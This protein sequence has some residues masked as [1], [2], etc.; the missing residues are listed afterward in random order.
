MPSEQGKEYDQLLKVAESVMRSQFGEPDLP[1]G[2][3]SKKNATRW[4]MTQF[5]RK[6]ISLFASFYFSSPAE[7]ES[8]STSET[9]KHKEI[10]RFYGD[11]F[12]NYSYISLFLGPEVFIEATLGKLLQD[13]E[14]GWGEM[15]D[16][17]FTS[18]LRPLGAAGEYFHHFLGREVG[19]IFLDIL[20]ETPKEEATEAWF[21]ALPEDSRIQAWV[22]AQCALLESVA[23]HHPGERPSAVL[24]PTA[25]DWIQLW[26][27]GIAERQ[28]RALARAQCWLAGAECGSFKER[29][30][31]LLDFDAGFG[32]ETFRGFTGFT[33]SRLDL[34]GTAELTGLPERLTIQGDLNLEGCTGLVCLPKALVV[35]GSLILKDCLGF[36]S[37]SADLKVGKGSRKEVVIDLRGCPKWDRHVPKTA[38]VPKT[39]LQ[40]QP[41]DAPRFEG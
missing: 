32:D 37:L 3:L 17:T 1:P 30:G 16:S 20:N 35:D 4:H 38:K 40:G 33:F 31:I 6:S 5:V 2:E 24:P 9:D 41:P 26:H 21:R 8:A 7:R 19:D 29:L 25:Q 39:I 27:S 22:E 18:Y 14:E 23:G 34:S 13:Q 15:Y 11:L 36:T 28:K 12:T 10:A